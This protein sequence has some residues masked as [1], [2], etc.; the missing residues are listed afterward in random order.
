MCVHVVIANRQIEFEFF[1][2]IDIFC[3]YKYHIDIHYI[4]LS[5]ACIRHI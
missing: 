4:F 1:L 5:M 2:F 3:L